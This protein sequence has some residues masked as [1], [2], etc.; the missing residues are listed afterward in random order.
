MIIMN[1]FKK[2]YK[3][4]DAEALDYVSY[5]IPIHCYFPER[6]DVIISSFIQK[7]INSN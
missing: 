7:M 5:L 1:W 2:Q 4:L 3:V 6:K